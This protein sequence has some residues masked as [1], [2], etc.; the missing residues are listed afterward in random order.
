MIIWR[1]LGILVLLIVIVCIVAAMTL[2]KV[3]FSLSLALLASVHPASAQ[4]RPEWGAAQD[5]KPLVIPPVRPFLPPNS[6]LTPGSVNDGASSPYS[7]GPLFDPTRDQATPG[8]RLSIPS[9]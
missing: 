1:G 7:S 2:S 9:R 6:V 8:F 4:S 3:V 5:L